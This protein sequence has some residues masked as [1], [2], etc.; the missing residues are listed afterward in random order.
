MTVDEFREYL[1][2]DKSSLDDELAAQSELFYA[3]GEMYVTAVSIRDELKETMATTDALLDQR[4]RKVAKDKVTE[5]QVK[6]QIQLE[7]EHTKAHNAY[8][9]AKTEA[10]ILGALKDAFKE[11][12]YMLRDLCSLY[13]SGYYETKSYYQRRERLAAGRK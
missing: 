2:I 10:D 11:R 8:L 12:G 4:V 13:V 5:A 9:E 6:G 3:I 1:K 7:P